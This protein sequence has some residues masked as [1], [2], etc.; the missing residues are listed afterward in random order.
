M[1]KKSLNLMLFIYRRGNWALRG[2]V[3][4]FSYNMTIVKMH[5]YYQL[6]V[7]VCVCWISG[8]Y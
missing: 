4:F 6:Y 1:I 2:Q 3:I 5:G 7:Y 8:M